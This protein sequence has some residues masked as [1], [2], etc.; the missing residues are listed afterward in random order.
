MLGDEAHHYFAETKEGKKKLTVAELEVRSWERTIDKILNLNSKNRMLGFSATLNLDTKNEILYSKLA[1]KI[2]YKYDLT[3]FMQQ[4][5]SK[6]V[7][8]L[9]MIEDDEVIMLHS[10]FLHLYMS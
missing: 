7:V 1:D 4:K 10:M 2:V 6:N 5:Y 9:Q 8:L 3:K